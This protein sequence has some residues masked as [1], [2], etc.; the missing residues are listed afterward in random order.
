MIAGVRE[1]WACAL[2][3]CAGAKYLSNGA[4]IGGFV[5]V[6]TICWGGKDGFL[7]WVVPL[8]A[9]RLCPRRVLAQEPGAGDVAPWEPSIAGVSPI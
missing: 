5:S 9:R 8:A 1:A 7:M 4:E 3:Q 6:A 2:R